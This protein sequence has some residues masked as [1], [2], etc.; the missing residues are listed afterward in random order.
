M[1]HATSDKALNKAMVVRMEVRWQIGTQEIESIGLC[2]HLCL[3]SEGD[4]RVKDNSQ[5][6]GLDTNVDNSLITQKWEK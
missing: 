5:T 2:K 3:E 4:E 1:V 6:S